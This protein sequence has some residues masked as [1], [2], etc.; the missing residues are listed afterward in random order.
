MNETHNWRPRLAPVLVRK[1]KLKAR[2]SGAGFLER[3]SWA[4]MPEI[5][6]VDET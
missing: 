6:R 3:K 4:P 1:M 5:M 2:S